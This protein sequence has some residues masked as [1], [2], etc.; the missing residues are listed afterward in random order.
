MGIAGLDEHYQ[1]RSLNLFPYF[2]SSCYMGFHDDE[3]VNYNRDD[4]RLLCRDFIASIDTCSRPSLMK[5]SISWRVRKTARIPLSASPTVPTRRH[6]HIILAKRASCPQHASLQIVGPFYAFWSSYSTRRTFSWL[7]KFDIREKVNRATL[8][9]ME[10]ENAKLRDAGRK[11]RN[12]EIRVCTLRFNLSSPS[13]DYGR[14]NCNSGVGG[15]CA[16]TGSTSRGATTIVGG[17][18][19]GAGEEDRGTEEGPDSR[20][21]RVRSRSPFP[22]SFP[23]VHNSIG[24][25]IVDNVLHRVHV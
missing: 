9:A 12:E 18:T 6:V 10:K 15:L 8:R 14:R 2:S 22:S 21:T 25:P 3:K 13:L 23:V 16:Q 20:A 4:D 11:E 1:D 17:E 5:T 24:M 19:S 7:D